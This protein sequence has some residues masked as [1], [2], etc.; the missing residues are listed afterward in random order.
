MN[1]NN[2]NDM[3]NMDEETVMYNGD[4]DLTEFGIYDDN[5]SIKI[6]VSS[7]IGTRKYQQDT[8]F[9]DKRGDMVI[10]VVCD[11]MGGMTSGDLASKTATQILAEDFYNMPPEINISEF[12]RAEAVKMDRAVADLV[13]EDGEDL[14]SGTTVVATII[15]NNI[16][17][18]M[19]V[20]DSRIYVIR[21][22]EIRA[23][24]RDHN[25]RLKLDA[26]LEAGTITMEEYRRE[27]SQAE[28]LISYIGIGN[29]PI[30]DVSIRPIQLI[31]N[32]IIIL[33]SDGLYK[34]LS[35]EDVLATV[36]YEE[37]DMKRAA[38]RLTDVVMM[39]T[40]KSQDNT[41]VVVMQYN[42]Y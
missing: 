28:A 37:P 3:H 15:K 39:R 32:D 40:Q 34:R 31:E 1:H 41:S 35:N 23:I 10:G 9:A 38:R 4:I 33:S 8:V 7:I 20:G 16:M 18:W 26:E 19:S 17:Y 27:E 42:R 6:G 25:L 2:M 29:V 21:N 36:M 11:G 30:I 12:L 24:N 5:L 14:G 22:G 13:N